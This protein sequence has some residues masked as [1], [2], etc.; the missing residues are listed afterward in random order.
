[1]PL[2]EVV[3]DVSILIQHV[4]VSLLPW[5]IAV[6]LAAGLGILWAS[7]ARSLFSR[8]SALRRASALLPWRT[9]AVSLPLLTP[10]VAAR[11]GLGPTAAGIAVGLFVFLFAL[12]LSVVVRLEKWYPSPPRVRFIGGVRTLAAA[13]VTVAAVAAPTVGGGGAGVL[14]FEGMRALDH[15][16][17]CGGFSAAVIL[18]LLIDLALGAAQMLFSWDEP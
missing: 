1:M 18:A 3:V 13:S 12:P 6:L 11:V 17:V 8:V 5:L 15:G 9:V 7:V 10:F 2:G 4:L 14:F 16:R